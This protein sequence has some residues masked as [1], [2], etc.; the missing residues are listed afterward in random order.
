ML[1]ALISAKATLLIMLIA[2][3]SAKANP[4]YLTLLMA[5]ISAE[6]NLGYLPLPPLLIV[7]YVADKHQGQT[8]PSICLSGA[9]T[10][11]IE[12]S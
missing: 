5:L 3:I 8:L 9:N 4:S 1:I 2:L 7:A 10:I 11:A 6:A 12:C